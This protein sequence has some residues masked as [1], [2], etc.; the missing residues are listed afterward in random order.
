MLLEAM[1]AL[2]AWL[3]EPADVERL[4]SVA[5]RYLTSDQAREHLGAARAAELATGQDHAVLLAIARGES[6][7]RA[8]V[9]F[10]ER[11]GALS[12]GVAQATGRGL[13]DCRRLRSSLAA[14]YLAGAELLGRWRAHPRCRG[15]IACGLAGY[16]G[17]LPY[18]NACADGRTTTGGCRTTSERLGLA[19]AIRGRRTGPALASPVA[20]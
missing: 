9:V 1:A 16:A 14:G 15:S 11:S 5:P 17:G 18:L 7:Y 6:N 13:A 4:R 8:D 20:W 2:L 10:V 3:A 12:C 19:A